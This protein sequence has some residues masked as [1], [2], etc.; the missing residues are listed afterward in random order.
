[1]KRS[2]NIVT[3]GGNPVTLLGKSAKPGLNAKNFICIGQNLKH[4]KLSDFSGK[5]RIISSVPSIDTGVCSAQT[6][7]FN[8]EADK[9]K[10]VQIISVS[11]DLPFALKRYC[12]AEGIKNITM[13]SDHKDLDFGVKY[14]LLIE[15]YRLLARAIIVIDKQDI[16]RYVQ[17][18]KEIGEHPD[19][20]KALAV[21][22]KYI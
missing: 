10:D 14:G 2:T 1:M 13:V 11:N 12:E 8:K 15:E 9:L 4:V 20:D 22:K 3:F 21:V 16:I 18:V 5:V 17:I 6:A 19:Y 7:R